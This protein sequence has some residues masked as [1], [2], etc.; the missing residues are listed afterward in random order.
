MFFLFVFII[1]IFCFDFNVTQFT[2]FF[3]LS[4]F[5]KYIVNLFYSI[6]LLRTK[7]VSH[8]VTN[9]GKCAFC[10]VRCCSI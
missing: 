2:I 9:F 10:T 8:A 6:R 5:A 7:K 3:G 4:F 1:I